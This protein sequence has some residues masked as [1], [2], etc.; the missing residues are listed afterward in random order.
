MN[1]PL[2]PSPIA[3][4]DFDQSTLAAEQIIALPAATFSTDAFFE[5]EMNA[6]WGHEWFCVGR[7]NDIP[8]AGDYYTIRVGKD[9]MIVI[10][11][12]DNEVKV[13]ANVCQHRGMIIAEG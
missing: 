2:V 5:F 6:V 3:I 8:I 9:P 1:R 12:R 10:R 11:N 7:A 13:L 4:K